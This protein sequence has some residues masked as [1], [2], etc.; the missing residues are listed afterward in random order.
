MKTKR[1]PI[2][3]VIAI[4]SGLVVLLG[5][6][7]PVPLLQNLRTLVLGWGVTLLGITT[8][9]GIA[10]L[11][12]VHYRKLVDPKTRS[13]F[14]LVV[15][16]AFLVTLAFGIVLTPANAGYQRV[17]QD[18]QVPLETSLMAM[19]SITMAA[20]CLRLLRNRHDMFSIV[21]AMSTIVFLVIGSGA[22]FFLKD[23]PLASG[24]LTVI[25]DL[26]LAGAR[27]I[28]LGIALGSLMTGIRI[29]IGSD[30]PY[31]G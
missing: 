20:G 4:S 6:I 21:F 1:T 23:I 25:Q 12:T 14:S 5:Y 11:V 28:L 8:L 18:I 29:L 24:I 10:N 13:P 9:L 16:L 3:V 15:L 31:S 30:K 22:L 26:P 17:V 27:G 2:I 7:I 19:L